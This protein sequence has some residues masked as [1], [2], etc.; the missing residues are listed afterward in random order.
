MHNHKK[1]DFENWKRV[2]DA[3][4]QVRY[5]IDTIDAGL[6]EQQLN[7]F[8]MQ[9]KNPDEFVTWFGLKYDLTLASQNSF[10]WP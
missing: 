8:W 7:S 10:N 3:L 2:V 9:M 1:I 4:M 6:D 5:C